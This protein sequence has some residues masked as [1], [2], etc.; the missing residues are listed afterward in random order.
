MSSALR[1]L[2]VLY[3]HLVNW[4]FK[5][6]NWYKKLVRQPIC[7]YSSLSR[8]NF[9]NSNGHFSRQVAKNIFCLAFFGFKFGWIFGC[10]LF[11]F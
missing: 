10:V 8:R 5:G 6:S 4:A 2:Q 1:V 7:L 11:D 9:L 3:G